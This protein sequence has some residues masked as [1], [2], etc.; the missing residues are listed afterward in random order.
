MSAKL[1]STETELECPHCQRSFIADI[2][3]DLEPLRIQRE[4]LLAAAKA[5]LPMAESPDD[6][7]E[8]KGPIYKQLCEAIALAEGK[9]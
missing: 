6:Y 3:L 9:P 5:A 7:W 8:I 1:K 2:E 4:S